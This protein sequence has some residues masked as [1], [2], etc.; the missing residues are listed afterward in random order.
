MQWKQNLLR[1]LRPELSPEERGL[2][3]RRRLVKIGALIAMAIFGVV[4]LGFVLFASP[5]RLSGGEIGVLAAVGAVLFGSRLV[6]AARR[7][8]SFRWRR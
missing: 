5:G 1:L 4:F 3:Q 2:R 7:I 6:S 8:R